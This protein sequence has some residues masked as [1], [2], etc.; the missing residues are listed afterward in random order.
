MACLQVSLRHANERAEQLQR[1]LTAVTADRD[2]LSAAVAALEAA[3]AEERQSAAEERANDASALAAE[4][5]A[6][7]ELAVL[8]RRAAALEDERAQ[9]AEGKLAAED[10]ARELREQDVRSREELQKAGQAMM[11]AQ[12]RCKCM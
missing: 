10:A 5:R 1:Q 8:R 7:Q 9:S 3:L 4:R 12:V 11:K 6:Q 2:R